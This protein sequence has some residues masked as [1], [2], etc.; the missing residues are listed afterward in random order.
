MK[1]TVLDD[2]ANALPT[3]PDESGRLVHASPPFNTGYVQ[4]DGPNGK[5]E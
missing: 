5:G 1:Q 2:N 3:M 4:T